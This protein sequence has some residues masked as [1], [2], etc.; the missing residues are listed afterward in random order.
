M[1]A[2]LILNIFLLGQGTLYK[3]LLAA[4]LLFYI[5]MLIGWIGEAT[6]KKIPIASTVFSFCV[7]SIGMMLGVILLL[8][9]RRGKQ[10]PGL[11][12]WLR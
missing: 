10:W 8:F 11:D 3:A 2:M 4:Q 9:G 5:F 1:I 6:K 12:L 7:A